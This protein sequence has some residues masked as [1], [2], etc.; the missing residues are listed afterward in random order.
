MR[1]SKLQFQDQRSFEPGFIFVQLCTL[2]VIRGTFEAV[3][4]SR[5]ERDSGREA[6]VQLREHVLIGQ[7]WTVHG[8]AHPVQIFVYTTGVTG[9]HRMT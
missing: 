7:P 6:R 1:T 2:L 4:W 8:Q 3:G 9:G 5:D